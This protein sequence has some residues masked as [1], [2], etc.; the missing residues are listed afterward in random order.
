MGVGRQKLEDWLN[1]HL[2]CALFPSPLSGQQ[3]ARILLYGESK[4][5][6]LD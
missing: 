4:T 1:V 2:K 6:I 3:L 5:E